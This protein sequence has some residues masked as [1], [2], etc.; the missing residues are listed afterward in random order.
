MNYPEQAEK[1][2][3]GGKVIIQYII[4]TFGNTTDIKVY[5]GVCNDLNQEAMRLTYLL[6]GWTPAAQNGKRINSVNKQPFIFVIDEVKLL[7]K[8]YD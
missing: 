8:N 1:Q 5:E 6:R 3:I 2:E 4:D 7:T